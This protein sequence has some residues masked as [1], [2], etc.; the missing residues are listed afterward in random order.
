MKTGDDG[1]VVPDE[2]Y[3][4][5]VG[6]MA[7]AGEGTSMGAIYA[8]FHIAAGLAHRERT[9]D[10]CFIDVSSAHAVIASAWLDA[11]VE[12]NRPARRGWWQDPDNLRPVARYQAYAARDGNYVLFCPEERKFWH[13]FC[14]LVGRPDLKDEKRG[15]GLRRE[16]QAILATRDRADWLALAVEHRIPIGPINNG[17]EEL[18]ADPQNASRPMFVEGEADGR[19]FTEAPEL[20]EHNQELLGELGY[21]ATEIDRLA[22]DKVIAAPVVTN[23]I[24]SAIYGES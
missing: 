15:E 9:G 19:P 8:A 12:I 24:A 21:G 23:H 7:A 2:T 22:A 18:C 4:R 14:D 17:I 10:G 20:G 1:L 6:S 5:R 16:I 3:L 13:V 11:T